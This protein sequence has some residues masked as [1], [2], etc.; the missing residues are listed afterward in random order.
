MLSGYFI[1]VDEDP[2]KRPDDLAF[3]VFNTT[4]AAVTV[5]P[6][7]SA[8]NPFSLRFALPL[9]QSDR[10]STSGTTTPLTDAATPPAQNTLEQQMQA[11]L[12]AASLVAMDITDDDAPTHLNTLVA[13][14]RTVISQTQVP[15]QLFP[16]TTWPSSFMAFSPKM[17]RILA[18]SDT[19]GT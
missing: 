1:H 19:A 17:A 11:L 14:L 9:P 7:L 12:D 3:F 15:R 18:S 16:S 2:T 6:C 8:I 10:P 13:Q 5:D 4:V